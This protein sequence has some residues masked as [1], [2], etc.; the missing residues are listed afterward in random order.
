MRNRRLRTIAF[1][2][3][4]FVNLS[5]LKHTL[6]RELPLTAHNTVFSHLKP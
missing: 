2:A 6:S 4:M 5:N 3:A 1:F